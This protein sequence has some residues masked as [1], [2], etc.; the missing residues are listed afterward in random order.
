MYKK[1]DGNFSYKVEGLDAIFEEKGNQFS[2]F[3]RVSFNDD[4]KTYL[5]IRRYRTDNEGNEEMA[6]GFTFL[7]PNGPVEAA[8]AIITSGFGQTDEYLEVLKERDDFDKALNKVL[9]PD[10]KRYDPDIPMD[11]V[12]DPTEFVEPEEENED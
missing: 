7:T 6:K 4:P 1:S 2:T 5:E 10:D 3:R 12:Y 9:G 8:K 11:A